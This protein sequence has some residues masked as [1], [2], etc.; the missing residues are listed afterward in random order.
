MFP[1]H[2]RH[3]RELGGAA[4]LPT[5]VL[6]LS[7]SSGC[8]PAP[9]SLSPPGL[10]LRG[11]QSSLSGTQ[12]SQWQRA[13]LEG[14]L[15]EGSPGE[16]WAGAPQDRPGGALGPCHPR[17]L[18]LWLCLA[19][20]QTRGSAPGP[21]VCGGHTETPGRKEGRKRESGPRAVPL[22]PAFSRLPEAPALGLCPQPDPSWTPS[23]LAHPSGHPAWPESCSHSGQPWPP[24]PPCGSSWAPGHLGQ[25]L[26]AL[27]LSSAPLTSPPTPR[28]S[29][30][31]S[32]ALAHLLMAGTQ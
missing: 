20:L 8:P 3:Q 15:G 23:E 11:L 29:A 32:R 30:P 27:R 2:L 1:E 5:W 24:P 10:G 12:G 21:R 18:R 31:C 17:A 28:R 22:C 7:R 26:Q 25:S 14:L 4:L 6:G 16:G 9:R 13:Q 19:S